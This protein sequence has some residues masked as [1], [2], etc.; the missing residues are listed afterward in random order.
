MYPDVSAVAAAAAAG[1]TDSEKMDFTKLVCSS[2][3]PEQ[4]TPAW[5][6]KCRKYQTTVQTR[7][8][9]ALPCVLSLNCGMDNL[10]DVAYWQTQLELIL[11]VSFWAPIYFLDSKSLSA[12][13][14]RGLSHKYQ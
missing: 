7:R 12:T 11:K 9:K 8:I 14:F 6:E 4:S 13:N 3:C 1:E 10:Q 2:L 5:C